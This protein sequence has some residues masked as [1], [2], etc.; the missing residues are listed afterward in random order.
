M[1]KESKDVSEK[2]VSPFA[3]VLRK[4]MGGE[5]EGLEST[6][7]VTS[8]NVLSVAIGAT[9]QAVSQYRNGTV[10]PNAEKLCQLAEYFKVS[11]D[12]L[13]GRTK[14]PSG[15]ADDSAIEKRFHLT[16]SA[17]KNL[18]IATTHR[19]EGIDDELLPYRQCVDLVLGSSKFR[20]FICYLATYSAMDKECSGDET[21][22]DTIVQFRDNRIRTK[23]QDIKLAKFNVMDQGQ[24]LIEDVSERW[25]SYGDT[26]KEG[27]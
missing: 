24:K 20:A 3:E 18:E 7:V 4:L 14:I 26:S 10:M 23:A 13:L 25:G 22:D 21:L 5:I 17:I 19:I 9:R 6:G 15:N 1:A 16:T 27:E 12:F 11:V 2:Y 8:Q